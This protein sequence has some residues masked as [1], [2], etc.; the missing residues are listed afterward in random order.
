[1]LFLFVNLSI[2]PSLGNK[3]CLSFREWI[4]PL[5][6]HRILGDL[7]GFPL[8]SASLAPPSLGRACSLGWTKHIPSWCPRMM[9]FSY[10][11]LQSTHHPSLPYSEARFPTLQ[12]TV[13]LTQFDINPNNIFNF[14]F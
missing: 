2:P 6:K 13:T 4:L 7:P 9:C 1:M 5:S 8:A 10:W 3:I 11:P 14:S 12:L